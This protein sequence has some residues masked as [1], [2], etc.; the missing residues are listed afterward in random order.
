MKNSWKW[1]LEQKPKE[2]T[3][4]KIKFLGNGDKQKA[5]FRTS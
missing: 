5:Y 2:F 1:F 4:V 3:E